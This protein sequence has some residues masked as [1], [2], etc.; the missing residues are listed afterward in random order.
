MLGVSLS[1]DECPMFRHYT[2]IAD[3]LRRG[4]A[5]LA[6][7]PVA[8]ILAEDLAE[9]PSTLAHHAAR[10][11]AR[12]LLFAPAEA[13][14]PPAFGSLLARIDHAAPFDGGLP[15]IVS[16]LMPR[17]PPGTWIY[18]GHNAEYLFH[19]F[20]E[21][22]SVAEMLAFHAEERRGAMFGQVVDLYA[23]DLAAHPDGIDLAAPCFD[24]TGYYAV[25]RRAPDGAVADRQLDLH[26]G[27]RWR[28]DDHVPKGRRRIDRVPLFRARPGLR[29]NA[30]FTLNDPELNTYACR[31]HNS[32]TCAVASFRAA[33]ALRAN[34]ASREVI[35][36][37]RWWGSERFEWSSAQLLRAGLMECDQWF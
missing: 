29:M 2:S 16:A 25:E 32:L 11:F 37:F 8:V 23:A 30:D 18:A 4:Q 34:P 7:G 10:G 6:E 28:F 9:I 13:V 21:T 22:R 24:R 36:T 15:A 14:V 33:K 1:G 12:L 3:F 35:A 19:P 31:W 26:G 17:V 5:A 27:L 20:C